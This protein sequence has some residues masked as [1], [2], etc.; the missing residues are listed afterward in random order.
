[1]TS[2]LLE[3]ELEEE[4]CALTRERI[5][6]APNQQALTAARAALRELGRTD[7]AEEIEARL[8]DSAPEYLDRSEELDKEGRPEE[9]VLVLM[10]APSALPGN[11]NILVNTAIALIRSLREQ[12]WV[13]GTADHAMALLTRARQID[14]ENSRAN[15]LIRPLKQLARERKIEN[16]FSADPA[17]PEA[18]ASRSANE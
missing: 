18:Q 3:N 17:A 8:E 14:P 11:P 10:Q 2:Q 16:A 9:A 12:G 15:Q 1:M 13:M 6:T 5:R 7:L 4:A